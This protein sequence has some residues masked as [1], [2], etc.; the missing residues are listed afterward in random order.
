[1][2]EQNT[3]REQNTGDVQG[4]VRERSKAGTHTPSGPQGKKKV[5]VRKK[6]RKKKSKFKTGLLIYALVLT[7][8]MI[9]VWIF[10]YSFI[11]GYE[12]GMPY[13]TMAKV[14]AE[15][16]DSKIEQLFADIESENE[17]EGKDVM[18]AYVKDII[19]DQEI[20]YQ[21]A[22]ENT[23]KNPVYEL[24]CG[25]KSFAKVSLKKVGKIKHGFKK[26]AVDTISFAEYMPETSSVTITVPQDAVVTIN[27]KEVGS[28]YITGKDVE[29]EELNHVAQYLKQVPKK[30]TYEAAGFFE[31]PQIEV[32]NA[33]GKNL[34]I[35][36]KE[37]QYVAGFAVDAQT[38]AEM[39]GY[40]EEVTDAYARNFANLGKAIYQ[41]VMDQSELSDAIELSTTYFYPTEYISGTEFAS[42]EIT[43]FVRYT[44]D[45]FS[46]HVKYDY[47]IHFNGYSIDH[48]T[49]SVDMIWTFVK[50]GD[51]W[52]LTDTK[53]TE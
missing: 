24:M 13:N 5:Q 39:K 46:C 17:F 10:F 8:I 53:Y 1:M 41:Y 44:E 42:R 20:T 14:A 50:S 7:V 26:W 16:D 45:C 21:E 43:D 15:F 38:E 2:D 52:Y 47:V 25:D 49:S 51:N 12:K 31:T 35:E 28:S 37:N 22:K 18:I 23:A 48:D 19:K 34:D 11:D 4:K 36:Q 27:G 40:V 33:D 6:K 32:K 30:V 3:T 9:G 29:V